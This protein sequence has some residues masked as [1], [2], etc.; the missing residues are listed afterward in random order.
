MQEKSLNK[1]PDPMPLT[2]VSSV[3]DSFGE[4]HYQE[5]D[6]TT[7]SSGLA[8]QYDID[9]ISM[10]MDS[11]GAMIDTPT[12]FDWVCHIPMKGPGAH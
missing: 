4:G 7:P 12:N 8:L 6:D 3:F 9:G 5:S 10:P 1:A 2:G 11:L